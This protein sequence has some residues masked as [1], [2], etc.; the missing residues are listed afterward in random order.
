M[1]GIDIP[2]R[3]PSTEHRTSSCVGSTTFTITEGGIITILN[4]IDKSTISTITPTSS[5]TTTTYAGVTLSY[6]RVKSYRAWR[7]IFPGNAGN[8]L[9]C[10]PRKPEPHPDPNRTMLSERARTRALVRFPPFGQR[11]P[12][13]ILL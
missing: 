3:H 6:E 13:R 9:T 7:V 10:T 4:A 12:R 1:T 2:A 5:T 11:P 8:Y